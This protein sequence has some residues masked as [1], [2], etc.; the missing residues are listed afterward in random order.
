MGAGLPI[1]CYHKWH[2][3]IWGFLVL[4]WGHPMAVPILPPLLS[5]LPRAGQGF[6]SLPWAQKAQQ[7]QLVAIG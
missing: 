6:A 4:L 5:D 2:S 1:V 3:Q 7:F